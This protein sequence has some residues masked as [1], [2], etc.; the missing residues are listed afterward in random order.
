M[1]V[2]EDDKWCELQKKKK[3]YFFQEEEEIVFV[4]VLSFI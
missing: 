1:M 3:T 4:Y 2:Y